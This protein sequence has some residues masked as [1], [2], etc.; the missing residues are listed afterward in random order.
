MLVSNVTWKSVSSEQIG[1]QVASLHVPAAFSHNSHSS[2]WPRFMCKYTDLQSPTFAC[3]ATATISLYRYQHAAQ[4]SHSAQAAL[5][6]EVAIS[7]WPF[8]SNESMFCHVRTECTSRNLRH[9]Q[10]ALS[11]ENLTLYSRLMTEPL[12]NM[13][14]NTF[15]QALKP[16]NTVHGYVLYNASLCVLQAQ[17]AIE[18]STRD[19]SSL[20]SHTIDYRITTTLHVCGQEG[21]IKCRQRPIH[22]VQLK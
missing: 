19:Q 5:G 1:S 18:S 10:R 14:L 3:N 16:R 9:I 6:L 7:G 8:S 11:V 22:K 12:V 15:K 2:E 17:G 21:R 4:F 20:H 13:P